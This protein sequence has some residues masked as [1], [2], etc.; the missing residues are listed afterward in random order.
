M[1]KHQGAHFFTVGQRKG[2]NVGGKQEPLFVIGTDVAG[3]RIYVGQGQAHPGL[4]RPGLK[5]L[6]QDIH[7][8]RPDLVLK[9][10]E[11]RD[12]LVRIRYR[13]PL[14]EA[15]L[16]SG[17]GIEGDR[18]GGHPNRNLNI[19]DQE[20]H[21]Q[22]AAEDYPTGP[23]VLGENLVLS[24]VQLDRQP[25]GTRIRIGNDAVIESVELRTGCH[26]LIPL[27]PRLPAGADDRLGVMARVIRGGTIRVGDPVVLLAPG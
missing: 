13:Q 26:K 5:V 2:L 9:P 17:Y 16:L 8:L 27:D 4:F 15:R 25:P 22:L 1:G 21:H 20:T 23:G 18:K 3:N 11:S 10:G 6:S 14:Q 24:G 12:L 19:M 7:W